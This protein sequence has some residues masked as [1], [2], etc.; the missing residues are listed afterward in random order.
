MEIGPLS[1]QQAGQRP[2]KPEKPESP[3]LAKT[4][5]KIIDQVEISQEARARLG[6]L[7]DQELRKEQQSPQS[8]SSERLTGK[9]RIDAIQQRIK[10]GYYDNP[11]VKAKIADKLIDDMEL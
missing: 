5:Q 1:T 7:A 9:D 2:E 3:P 4:S 6:E 11:D 8:V 10:S